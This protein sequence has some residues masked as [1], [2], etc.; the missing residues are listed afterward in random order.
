M[1]KSVITCYLGG[2]AL[3]SVYFAYASNSLMDKVI[4]L[5]SYYSRVSRVD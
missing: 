3:K 1:K 4:I 5:V 2:I